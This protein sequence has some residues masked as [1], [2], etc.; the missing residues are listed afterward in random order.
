MAAGRRRWALAA[1]IWAAL[2][3]GG[4]AAQG[5]G[6]NGGPAWIPSGNTFELECGCAEGGALQF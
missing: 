4:A 6:Y 2:L 5:V 3:L 1:A